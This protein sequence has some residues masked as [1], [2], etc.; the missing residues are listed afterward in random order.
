MATYI[1]PT[2]PARIYVGLGGK[3][4]CG[5]WFSHGIPRCGTGFWSATIRP[6]L[7]WSTATSES[8]TQSNQCRSHT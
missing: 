8:G 3:R 2:Y 4:T 1:P 7:C 6:A 5:A